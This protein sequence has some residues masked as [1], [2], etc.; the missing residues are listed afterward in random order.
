MWFVWLYVVSDTQLA[1]YS[2][3]AWYLISDWAGGGGCTALPP[4][5]QQS[6]TVNTTPLS[7]P[8][9]PHTSWTPPTPSTRPGQGRKEDPVFRFF[10]FMFTVH[11]RSNHLQLSLWARGQVS[12]EEKM[13]W[14]V[15]GLT[16][17]KA[18]EIFRWLFL[19]ILMIS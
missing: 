8:P 7:P 19:L 15:T 14:S 6:D 1:T 4:H 16:P 11:V 18:M 3:S 10:L 2:L 17:F 12:Q 5:R 13:Y 9:S